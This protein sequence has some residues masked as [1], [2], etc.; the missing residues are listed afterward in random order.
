MP[1]EIRERLDLKP[2]TRVIAVAAGDADVA[3]NLHPRYSS[4]PPV[5]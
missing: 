3:G 2:G 5:S 4:L 1:L